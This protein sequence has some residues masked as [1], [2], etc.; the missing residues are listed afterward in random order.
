[1]FKI[2]NEDCNNTI[3]KL[4]HLDCVITSPPYNIGLKY[5]VY[6]DKTEE[7]LYCDWLVNIFLSLK[8]KLK[9]NGHIF[10]NI[11]GTNLKPLLP[12]YFVTKMSEHFV[13]QNSIQWVKSISINDISYGHFKPVNSKRFLNHTHE[14]IFHFTKNGNVEID[15]KSIGVPYMDKSNI[16]RRNHSSDLRCK[17][18]VWYIPYKTVNSKDQ[19]YNH[20]GSFPIELPLQCL[21]LTGIE[22]GNVYDPFCGTGTTLVAAKKLKWNSYGSEISENYFKI[23][24]QRMEEE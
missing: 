24:Q 20:P 5:D 18:D 17:G 2:F 1:M 9:D 10:V 13:L 23:I 8:E 21:K 6:N 14:Y 4:P 16:K 22:H 11:D 7:N 3:E 19:K 15:R 12:F